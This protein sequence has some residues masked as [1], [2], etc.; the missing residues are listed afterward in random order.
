MDLAGCPRLVGVGLICHSFKY[1]KNIFFNISLSQYLYK[2][3]IVKYTSNF[4]FMIK[5]F[6][7]KKHINNIL[8]ILFFFTKKI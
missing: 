1:L 4:E 8:D 7:P 6:F 3:I 5:F 2:K